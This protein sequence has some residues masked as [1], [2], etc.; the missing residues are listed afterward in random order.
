MVRA[1]SSQ[2]RDLAR[3][4]KAA[5]SS[6]TRLRA[7]LQ[8]FRANQRWGSS[9]TPMT[10]RCSASTAATA[11]A[12]ADRPSHEVRGMALLCAARTLLGTLTMS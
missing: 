10:T 2:K 4:L 11:A 6:N 7:E 5:E 9:P 3:R 12:V 8:D 1:M